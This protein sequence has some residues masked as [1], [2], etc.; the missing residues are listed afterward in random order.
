MDFTAIDFE[1]ANNGRHSA[2]QLAAVKVRGGTIVDRKS[3]LIKPRPF[4]FNPMNIQIHGIHP[5]AVANEPEFGDCWKSI[6]P[7]FD[8]ECDDKCLIAHN[9]QFDISVLTS[10]LNYHDIP[11]PNLE[12][13]CTR[14]VARHAWPGRSSYGLKA[15]ASWL[16]V[17]FRHH[18]AL[19][20]SI[21]CASILLAAANTVGASSIKE[22]EAKLTLVRGAAGDWGYRGATRARLPRKKPQN[23][24]SA[25]MK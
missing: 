21:A 23:S 5:G 1:T 8:N 25:I 3:W 22:L 15:L 17:E 14:L 6:A 13:S 10:C 7:C 11:V 18:D 12:F 20:D 9:A 24:I 16:G 4:F 19:E 2:C